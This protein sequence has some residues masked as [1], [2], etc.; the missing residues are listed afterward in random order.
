MRIAQ[1][2]CDGLMTAAD[3]TARRRWLRVLALT[4][5]D[6]LHGIADARLAGESFTWLRRPESGLVMAQ[7][8]AGN[9]G[10][11]FNLA[12]VTVSRCVVRSRYKTVGVGYALGRDLD[13]IETIAKLDAL[14]QTPRW[15]AELDAAVVAPLAAALAATETRERLDAESTR[16]AF[17]ALEPETPR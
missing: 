8:R 10:E 17:Y 15:R 1:K 3:Q 14:L 11:R 9:T 7:A 13:R 12:E 4:P 5:G 16:V 2:E 6:A